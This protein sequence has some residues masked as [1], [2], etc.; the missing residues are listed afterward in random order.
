[1]VITLGPVFFGIVM[2][3]IFISIITGLNGH[4]RNIPMVDPIKM[5]GI[6][7]HV[8]LKVAIRVND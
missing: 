5:C 1:M 6:G 4:S 8:K 3:N 7:A 2:A